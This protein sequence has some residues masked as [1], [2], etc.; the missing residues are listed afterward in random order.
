MVQQTTTTLY[1]SD[2]KNLFFFQLVNQSY[3]ITI[4]ITIQSI[5]AIA[6][7]G[8]HHHQIFLQKSAA[9]RER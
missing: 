9:T 5:M 6:V 1:F 3:S 8:Y 4:T 2:V 7:G